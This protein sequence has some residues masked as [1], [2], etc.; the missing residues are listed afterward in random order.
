MN[1]LFGL[2]G[3]VTKPA[4]KTIAHPDRQGS[5]RRARSSRSTKSAGPN[6]RQHLDEHKLALSI[7]AAIDQAASEIG[8]ATDKDLQAAL[9]ELGLQHAFETEGAFTAW[10]ALRAMVLAETERRQ[11]RR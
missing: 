6:L 3:A 7:A 2:S 9:L 1:G 4:A 11:E 10:S 8:A 5:P